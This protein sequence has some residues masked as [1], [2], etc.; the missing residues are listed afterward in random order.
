MRSG[1]VHVLVLR[2]LP[3]CSVSVRVGEAAGALGSYYNVLASAGPKGNEAQ[4]LDKA[5]ERPGQFTLASSS[6]HTL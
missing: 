4:P 5:G 1:G 6:L 3:G 2:V